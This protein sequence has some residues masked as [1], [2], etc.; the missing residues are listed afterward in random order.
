MKIVALVAAALLAASCSSKDK[1]GQ[2][3]SA[4]AS[5]L[6]ITTAFA[7][8]PPRKGSDILTVTLKDGTGA[9]VKGA[10][11]QVDT[12][13]PSMSMPGPSVTAHNNGDGTYFARL[14]LQYA[15]SWQFTVSAKAA[16]KTGTARIT[17]D[18]K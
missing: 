12:T 15:T 1:D 14:A 9:P 3:G 7:P 16:E 8:E 11:V 10:I 4:G 2:T 6:R 13:M 17:A 5:N 18:V